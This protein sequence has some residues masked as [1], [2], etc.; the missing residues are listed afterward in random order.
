MSLPLPN[1]RAALPGTAAS[2]ASLVGALARPTAVA[3][4]VF[5]GLLATRWEVLRLPPYFDC[6]NLVFREADYLARTGFDYRALRYDE[7][8][9]NDG[10]AQS[11]MISVIPSG[12]A[13]LMR[14]LPSSQAVL[15]VCHVLTFLAAAV[16]LAVVVELVLPSGGWW[17]AL[18]VG[19]AVLST[20]V[21]SAQVDM[22]G[23]D[24]PMTAAALVALAAAAKGRW[25]WALAAAALS[26]ACKETGALLPPVM[27][28]YLAWR[29]V[30]EPRPDSTGP[31]AGNRWLLVAAAGW[32]LLFAAEYAL[33]S[34]SGMGDRVRKSPQDGSLIGLTVLACPELGAM[35]LA[36][37]L[38]STGV[39]LARRFPSGDTSGDSSGRTENSVVDRETAR[40]AVLTGLLLVAVLGAIAFYV[41]IHAPRYFTLAVP[42]AYLMWGWL[43]CWW[44]RPRLVA[45]LLALLATF[46]LLNWDGRFYLPQTHFPRQS[47]ERSRGE[48]LAD[49]RANLAAVRALVERPVDLP[50]LAGQPF[51][52]FLAFP[53]L[54]YVQRPLRGYSI[55]TFV[56]PHFAPAAQMLAD[57]P[58]QVTVIQV[59]NIYYQIGDLTV[60]HRLPGDKLVFH[61]GQPSPLVVFDTQ[62]PGA[63]DTE[64]RRWMLEH[65]WF[66]PRVERWR[67]GTAVRAALLERGGQ[68][69]E[70]LALLELARQRVPGDAA[71]R[72][73]LGLRYLRDQRPADARSCYE[74]AVRLVPGEREAWL[75]LGQACLSTGDWRGAEEAWD[76]ADRLEPLPEALRI[77]FGRW[78]VDA[79]RRSDAGAD[80]TALLSAAQSQLQRLTAAFG[81]SIDGWLLAGELAWEQRRPQDAIAAYRQVLK[82]EPRHAQ[83]T[84]NLAWALAAAAPIGSPEA[85]EAIRLAEQLVA[86]SSGAGANAYDTL[87]AAYAAGGRWGAAVEAAE[88]AVALAE[89]KGDTEQAARIGRRLEG[90]RRSAGEVK[91][92]Q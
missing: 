9:V 68:S 4:V 63:G 72:L 27:L 81:R 46:N 26:F 3:L 61:D 5:L 48:Y 92:Q 44:G 20:P 24:V 12:I 11:Y 82:I 17:L 22:L 69:D 51:V 66:D 40:W 79:A 58:A 37:V 35:L 29:L 54:G 32:M 77:S 62:I 65:W 36:G 78:L 14:S 21:F 13:L 80:Q 76:R 19:A 59:K 6:A 15:V 89:A 86:G 38:W 57:A 85:T 71:A 18:A 67:L 41:R 49:H 74:E 60:P 45:A 55:N 73:D 56:G 84:N 8:W 42:C 75:G 53:N 28:G 87:A 31:T 90:Y 70:A 47:V 34:W 39:A 10:G 1:S 50:I 16:A 43:G 33:H 88:R 7:P 52:D 2:P 91:R 25:G 30:L 23:L 64:R 83:A